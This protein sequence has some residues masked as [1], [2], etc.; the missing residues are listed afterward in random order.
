MENEFVIETL[1]VQC[2]S[3]RV[4]LSVSLPMTRHRVPAPLVLFLEDLIY[5]IFT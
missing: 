2:V 3:T 5:L 1:Q 4:F